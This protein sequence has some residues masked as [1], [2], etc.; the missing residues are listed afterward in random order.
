MNGLHS[1]FQLQVKSSSILNEQKLDS[2]CS[3]LLQENIDIH[4]MSIQ[5]FKPTAAWSCTDTH[6]TE[7]NIT[8]ELIYAFKRIIDEL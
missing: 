7:L 6:R 8:V 4:M 3:L 5:G 1:Y 2:T